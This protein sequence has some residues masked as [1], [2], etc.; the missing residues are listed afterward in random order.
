MT[1]LSKCNHTCANT[2]HPWTTSCSFMALELFYYIFKSSFKIYGSLYLIAALARRKDL[3][4]FKKKL[5]GE[6]LQSTL[7]LSLNGSLFGVGLCAFRKLLGTFTVLTSGFLPG[8]IASYI[9]IIMERPQRRGMLALYMF[10]NAIEVVFNMLASRNIIP[11]LSYGEVYIFCCATAIG[12]YLYKEKKLNNGVLNK[13]IQFLLGEDKKCEI[14]PVNLT[15]LHNIFNT[16]SF[17]DIIKRLTPAGQAFL[18]GYIGEAAPR[19]LRSLFQ[20]KKIPGVL[21]HKNNLKLG[22][23]LSSFVM[24]YQSAE[25]LLKHIRRKT[26]S[27]NS[28]IAGGASGL[29]ILFYRSS[30]ISLYLFTK[31]AEILFKNAQSHGFLPMIPYAEIIVYT[32]STGITF[33]M[34]VFESHNVRPEYFKFLSYITN[35]RIIPTTKLIPKLFLDQH[36]DKS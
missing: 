8:S 6:V 14:N 12:M 11:R 34:C 25:F 5:V 28:F 23:F 36:R 20:P 24:L 33:H 2:I 31:V 32:I 26:D 18:I 15:S 7:F 22:L 9:A 10:N 29:S 30:T 13:S 19:L 3:E 21:V 35:D 17:K 4:Y 1:V 16:T 27:I